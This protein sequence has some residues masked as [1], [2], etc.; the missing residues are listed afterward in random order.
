MNFLRNLK[1][2]FNTCLIC[3]TD[4]IP[5]SCIDNLSLNT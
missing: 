1:K 3:I 5:L 4:H 2:Y